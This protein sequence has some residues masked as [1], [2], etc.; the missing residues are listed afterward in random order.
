MMSD[1]H[2]IAVMQ[3]LAMLFTPIFQGNPALLPLLSS[4]MVS[5]SLQFGNT[6]ASTIGYAG[7]GM[8][9]SAFLG[10]VEKGYCFGRVA[11][12]LLDR[13]NARQFKSLTLLLFSCFL[14]HRQEALRPTI[15]TTKEGYLAGMETGDFLYA[16]YNTTIYFDNNLFRRSGDGSIGNQKSKITVLS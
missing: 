9:L 8:V 7:Y 2:T 4:T 6:P 11:L 1:P 16:G 13:L 5:L 12:S 10:E 15:P 14:Q 3:L